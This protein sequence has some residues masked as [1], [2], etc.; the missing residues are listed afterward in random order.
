MEAES[1]IHWSGVTSIKK[2]DEDGDEYLEHMRKRQTKCR[3]GKDP[4]N[5]SRFKQKAWNNKEEPKIFPV[6]TYKEWWYKACAMW[7]NHI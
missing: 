4:E 3:N 1:N 2:T 5:L 6:K 7:L